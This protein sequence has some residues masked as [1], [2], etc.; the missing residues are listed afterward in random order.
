MIGLVSASLN[1]AGKCH[2]F[3]DEDFVD[4]RIFERKLNFRLSTLLKYILNW[5]YFECYTSNCLDINIDG[6]WRTLFLGTLGTTFYNF[7]ID[8]DLTWIELYYLEET[9]ISE[10]L[11]ENSR[12]MRALFNFDPFSFEIPIYSKST[13]KTNDKSTFLENIVR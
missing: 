12:N 13:Y 4:F 1:N 3:D 2:A 10:K 5:L 11:I 8:F 7:L 9:Y 6:I